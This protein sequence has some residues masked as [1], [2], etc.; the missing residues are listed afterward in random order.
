MPVILDNY[1]ASYFPSSTAGLLGTRGFTSV[2]RPIVARASGSSERHEL[3]QRNE[4]SVFILIAPAIHT[5]PP[6]VLGSQLIPS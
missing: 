5:A 1:A 6:G 4:P 3:Q 2:S